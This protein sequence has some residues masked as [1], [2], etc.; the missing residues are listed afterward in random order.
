VR[1]LDRVASAVALQTLMPATPLR[2]R[3]WAGRGGNTWVSSPGCLQFSVVLR[4]RNSATLVFIQYVMALAVVHAVRS[5]GPDYE[6]RA[7]GECGITAS[8][9]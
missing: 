9:N 8:C 6:V 7:A 5:I 4:H 2:L 3:A 1:L